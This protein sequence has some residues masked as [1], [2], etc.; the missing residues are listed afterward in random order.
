MPDGTPGSAIEPNDAF[1]PLSEATMANNQ[2]ALVVDRGGGPFRILYVCG[3]P[4]W[5]FKFLRRALESDDQLELFFLRLLR[6]SGS[7]ALAGMKWRSPSPA[8]SR[9]G[10][11]LLRNGLRLDERFLRSRNIWLTSTFP[12]C[13]FLASFSR[14]HLT[15][16]SV[17][18][19]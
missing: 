14:R 19:T 7:E 2:R 1:D 9:I 8:D 3:R 16:F 15:R 12:F 18:V 10:I 5:E 17:R 6:G 4:N 11:A 13:E